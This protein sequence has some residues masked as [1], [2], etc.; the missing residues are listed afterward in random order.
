[1]TS[2]RTIDMDK[3]EKEIDERTAAYRAVERGRK[4]MSVEDAIVV[5]RL[6]AERNALVAVFNS[7]R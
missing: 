6:L 3:L 1:M 2:L 4:R 7:L 5:T